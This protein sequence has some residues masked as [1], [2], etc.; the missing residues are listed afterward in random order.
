MFEA[1][2]RTTELLRQLVA[3][4]EPDRFDGSG[5]RTM[6]ELFA[7]ARAVGCGGQGP[8]DA[9]GDGDRRVEARR[10][11][12]RRR[13]L[14]GGVDRRHG[15]R[16]PGH[17]RHGAATA[18]AAGDG[19]RVACRR[20]LV[21]QVEAIADAAS[22]DPTAESDLLERAQ[23]DGVRGLRNECARVKAAACVDEHAR[24]ERIRQAR[25]LRSWTDADGTGRIDIRGPVDATSRVMAALAPFERELFD[26]ARAD[27]RRERSRRALVRRDGRVGRCARGLRRPACPTGDGHR[28]A[29]R[30]CRAAARF[31]AA[32]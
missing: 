22:A 19:S 9:S 17:P 28:G 8:G 3:E 14:V 30:P 4:F 13:Q 10:R 29:G 15:E 27:G 6:V 16:G 24:Y 7:E 1:L 25:S 21:P 18:R 31:D 2:R 23:H 11:P 26:E 12:P 5:A 20:A 32:R